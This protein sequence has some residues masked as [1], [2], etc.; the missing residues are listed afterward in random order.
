[1]CVHSLHL[2]FTRKAQFRDFHARG[3]RLSLQPALRFTSLFAH[4]FVVRNEEQQTRQRMHVNLFQ[5]RASLTV[6][7]A[8]Q[9]NH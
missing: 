2:V 5:I 9:G 7:N 1:M 3:C 8:N 6:R 4:D